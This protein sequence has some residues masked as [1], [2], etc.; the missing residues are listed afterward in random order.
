MH[1]S[2]ETDPPEIRHK[3]A[4]LHSQEAI[5]KQLSQ[6][7]KQAQIEYDRLKMEICVYRASVAPMQRCP[8]EV[9]LMI[10]QAYANKDASLATRLL[11]VCRRWHHIVVNAPGL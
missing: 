10:F 2:S 5:I 9:I 8:E 6:S 4:A 1:Y 7:L 11:S 3:L